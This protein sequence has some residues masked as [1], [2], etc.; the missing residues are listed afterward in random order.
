MR[1]PNRDLRATWLGCLLFISA[2]AAG[3]ADARVPEK[4]EVSDIPDA[5]S[6]PDFD[7]ERTK[8]ECQTA[9]DCDADKREACEDAFR[10][11]E[12]PVL[13]ER[14]RVHEMCR[15]ARETCEAAATDDAGRQ[16]CHTAEHKCTL[17]VD[18][19]EAVCHI[20]AEECIAA[21]RPAGAKPTMPPA[22]PSDAEKACHD[23]EHECTDA[24][25]LD[26]KDLPKPPMCGPAKPPECKPEPP[27]P[28]P[29]DPAV[30]PN[31]PIV[32]HET[33]EKT[34][35]ECLIAADCAADKRDACEG[36]FRTCEAPARAQRDALHEKC[37]TE[38]ET[39][40]AAATDEAGRHACHTA[41]HKCTLPLEPADAVCHV[42]A[43]E[44]LWAARPADA[45]PPADPP[46]MMP[47]PAMPP[48]MMPGMMPPA[49]PPPHEE[50]DAEKA[51]HEKEHECVESM[52]KEPADMPEVP[53]CPPPPPPA[54]KPVMQKP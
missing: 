40:E 16:A 20:D 50:S 28:P 17:P 7:C 21:A 2:A 54:C 38:R 3:C 45:K 18:P 36:A 49:P 39:C 22:P 30:D 5:L 32:G 10:T 42:D 6:Q 25:R 34:K 19:A 46:A 27:P 12:E 51:C 14:D 35:R 11:C 37:R 41:E 29:A 13:A 52:H 8:R 48:A 44:C 47:P 26:P 33:C 43:E 53:K 23:K 9:A 31:A 15:T 1:K 24:K 4:L